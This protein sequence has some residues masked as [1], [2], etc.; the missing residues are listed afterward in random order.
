MMDQGAG[1]KTHRAG[2]G[3]KVS[4]PL[5]GG[6]ETIKIKMMK[7]F[8]SHIKM[9]GITTKIGEQILKIGEVIFEG[10]LKIGE[11]ILKIG[12]VKTIG[13]KKTIDMETMKT[14]DLLILGTESS[15]E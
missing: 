12:E 7:M 11:G 8:I 2:S 6:G 15:I 1:A 5:V 14:T 10:I 9:E 13:D 4:I 3:V